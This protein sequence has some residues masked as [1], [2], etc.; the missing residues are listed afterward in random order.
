[1]ER[2]PDGLQNDVTSDFVSPH[3]FDCP[4]GDELFLQGSFLLL[5]ISRLP[6]RFPFLS[7]ELSKVRSL[8]AA[9]RVFKFSLKTFRLFSRKASSVLNSLGAELANISSSELTRPSGRS[10]GRLN[11]F[12]EN[13]NE[14]GCKQSWNLR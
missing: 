5:L 4:Q 10:S 7:A 12:K 8:P 1:M 11:I 3:P 2:S 6:R 13:L 14:S 9:G